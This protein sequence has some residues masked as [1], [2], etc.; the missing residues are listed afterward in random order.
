M[1]PG[2]LAQAPSAVAL[3]CAVAGLLVIAGT[4]WFAGGQH[5][6][7]TQLQF[8]L[9]AFVAGVGPLALA[10]VL[11]VAA[12]FREGERRVE[13][14]LARLLVAAAD[15]PVADAPR[16]HADAADFASGGPRDVEVHGDNSHGAR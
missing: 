3:V 5:T 9:V 11:H 2:R 10:G 8:V 16:G 4:T 15:Y 7:F 6:V 13:E 12:R 14:A 1:R